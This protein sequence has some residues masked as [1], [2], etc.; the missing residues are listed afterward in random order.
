M[1]IYDYISQFSKKESSSDGTNNNNTNTLV[2]VSKRMTR[3]FALLFCSWI[4]NSF[5]FAVGSYMHLKHGGPIFA[6][7]GEVIVSGLFTVI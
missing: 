3:R 5:G 6:C 2:T 7:F 4:M 1:D